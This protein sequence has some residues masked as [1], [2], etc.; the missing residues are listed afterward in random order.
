VGS[1]AQVMESESEVRAVQQS[2][3]LYSRMQSSAAQ[4]SAMQRSRAEDRLD[5]RTPWYK[6]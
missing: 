1:K 5:H 3:T 2:T 6:I 4:C